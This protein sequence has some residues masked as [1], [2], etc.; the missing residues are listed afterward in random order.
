MV[1]RKPYAFLIK[2][3]RRI[4]LVLLIAMI[5]MF[6]TSNRLLS[7]FNEYDKTRE[8]IFS[9]NLASQ[10]ITLIMFAVSMFIVALTVFIYILM[11][12]KNKPKKLYISMIIYYL[13]VLV[14]F[15]INITY[16]NKIQINEL[17]P[18]L[19]RLMRD[20]NLISVITQVLFSVL[21][22]VRTV[23]FDIKKFNFGEDIASLQ[24]EVTDNE[25]F[26]LTSGIN[27]DEVG[28]RYRKE[29][30]E[31]GYFYEENRK[32]IIG[33]I[34]TIIVFI[35]G[36]YLLQTEVINKV[37]KQGDTVNLDNLY[38]K[39]DTVYATNTNYNGVSI[40]DKGYTYVIVPL[41][42]DNKTAVDRVINLDNLRIEAKSKIYDAIITKYDYFRDIGIGYQ[43]Q[44]LKSNTNKE[45]IT[46][47]QIKNSDLKNKLTLRYT[48][49]VVY[50]N[51]NLNTKYKR[52]TIVPITLDETTKFASTDINKDIYFGLS[53][54]KNT[55]LR[56]TSVDF[57]NQYKYTYSGTD[58]YI[59]EPLSTNTIM[60]VSYNLSLDSTLTYVTS[61]QDI[62]DRFGKITYVKDKKTYTAYY[63]AVTPTNYIG[64][65]A[66]LSVN[67]DIKDATNIN[68]IITVRNKTYT[69]N[70]K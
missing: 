44:K 40:E 6:Y 11:R 16:L 66:Y 57:N 43:D 36:F 45:Y 20:F 33:I 21:I 68:L 54:L 50:N 9:S 51:G 56:I 22:F 15:I 24:I 32:I 49:Q 67:S 14:F 58:Y 39:V 47:F 53:L 64:N 18:Q 37:Y 13:V 28:R 62:L 63:R 30:R 48:R 2:N 41:I 7:F 8:A 70:L 61:F 59:N 35:G 4:H 17:S 38:L 10:Y 69:Y 5:Y 46:V 27:T 55:T 60:K 3:F 34:V 19:V 42:L 1:L 65:D 52:I 23:G 29:L 31:L 26:E 25:E 12:Q